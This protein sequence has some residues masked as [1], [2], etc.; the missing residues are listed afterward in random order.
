MMSNKIVGE[1]VCGDY[2][3]PLQTLWRRGFT[4]RVASAAR[5]HPRRFR[6]LRRLDFHRC[7]IC[8]SSWQP[9]FNE[10][11]VIDSAKRSRELKLYIIWYSSSSFSLKFRI[12]RFCFNSFVYTFQVEGSRNLGLSFWWYFDKST[13]TCMRIVCYFIRQSSYTGL[14]IQW[15][16]SAI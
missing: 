15:T 3:L 2:L 11:I 1:V 13:H 4:D 9:S 7:I 14:T 5:H 8:E 6:C 10:S 12:S 16:K